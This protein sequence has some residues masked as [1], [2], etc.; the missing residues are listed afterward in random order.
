[1]KVLINALDNEAI[2]LEWLKD[3]FPSNDYDLNLFKDPRLFV[4]AFTKNTDLIITDVRVD[5]YDLHKTLKHFKNIREG[6]Y[7]IVISGFVDYTPSYVNDFLL[8]LFPLGVNYFIQKD[9][10]GTDWLNQVR[11]AVEALIPRMSYRAHLL[12]T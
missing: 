5:G 10:I 1:M 7:I 2:I 8:P 11:D 4:E 9:T 3:L 12:Q 6:V